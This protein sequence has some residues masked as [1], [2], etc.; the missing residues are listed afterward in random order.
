VRSDAYRVLRQSQNTIRVD[1]SNLAQI[2]VV[3]RVLSARRKER[4]QQTFGLQGKQAFAECISRKQK[5]LDTRTWSTEIQNF[6]YAVFQRFQ[7]H[8]PTAT[9]V[10]YSYFGYGNM[11]N[12]GQ[13]LPLDVPRQPAAY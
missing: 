9:W 7:D 1:T 3:A 10:G 5:F 13:E 2:K 6:A 8:S 4:C 11:S 12:S